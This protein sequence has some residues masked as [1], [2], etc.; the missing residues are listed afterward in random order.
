M[1]F[2]FDLTGKRVFVAGHRG[3]VGGALARRLEEEKC[4]ILTA[5]RDHLDLINQ[6]A[7]DRW[8]ADNKPDV[9]LVAAAKVGGIKANSTLPVD[10]LYNNL[11]IETNLIHAA[12]MNNVDRLLFLGSSCIYPRLA[13]QPM[14]EEAL[15]TGPLEPTNEWYAIAKIAGIRL[16]QA[17]RQQYGRDYI[18]V[19]PTNLY[20][21]GDNFHPEHSHVPA[22]LIRRFH[23]AKEQGY[24]KVEVWGSGTPLRE[25]LYVDDL[26]D[27]CIF[28][29]KRYSAAEH[30]NIGSGEEVSIATFARAVKEAVGYHG[31]LVFDTNKPDGAPRK[32]MDC[33]RLAALGWRY[34]TPLEQGLAQA[35]RWY[36]DNHLQK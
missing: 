17:Y 9:V 8:M 36:L 10:F 21:P 23:E 12:H 5:D 30:I 33:S 7:V 22:S 31:E 28:L 14:T 34:Q 2:S 26:A 29:L 16:C 11:M 35:Y 32:L 6:A 15:L 19:M 1:T 18:S 13:P 20:G 4:T 24:E 25:F 3:M 27:A